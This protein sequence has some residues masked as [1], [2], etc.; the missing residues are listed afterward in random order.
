VVTVTLALGMHRMARRH[1][2]VKKLA[3]V[4]TLGCTTVICSD[5]TGTLTLNQMTARALSAGPRHAVSGE[6]Y[7]SEGTIAGAGD[8]REVLLPAALCV[9]ARIRDGELIGDPTEGAAGAGRQ[10]R[11]RRRPAAGA[12]A[13]DRRDSLRFGHQVHGHLPPRRRAGAAVREG[14]AGCAR[15][16]GQCLTD[17]GPQPLD[18]ACARASRPTTRPS[19]PRPCACWRWAAADPRR[20]VRPGRRPAAVGGGHHP[21]R[22]RRHHRPAPRRGPRGHRPLPRRRHR[23]E[24]DHR[25]PPRHRRAIARELGLAGETHEGREL[26]GLAPAEVAALVEKSAVF[27]RVAPEH[28][29]RIVEPCRAAATWWR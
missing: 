11:A 9:D 14:R 1:A 25:R 28:K 26:D 17:A 6:G 18:A 5:K 24:D 20:P 12:P 8:L 2:I 29:L 21:P 4:E 19:P 27:A 22:P 3:A 10:G 23:G 16:G 7:G 13:A 15:S